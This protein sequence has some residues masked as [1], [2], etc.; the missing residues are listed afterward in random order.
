MG[1]YVFFVVATAMWVAFGVALAAWPVMLDRAWAGVRRVPLVAKPVV[2]IALLPWLSGLAI[3]ESGWHAART[4][5]RRPRRGAGVHRVLV[6]GH[7]GRGHVAMSA[8]AARP[9]QQTPAARRF[10]HLSF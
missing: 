2:W 1:P 5:D 7:P 6:V 3:W 9:P 8:T 4:P 10:A